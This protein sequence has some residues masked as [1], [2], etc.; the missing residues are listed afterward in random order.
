[1]SASLR[2]E[3]EAVLR[4]SAGTA[5]GGPP[6]TVEEVRHRILL[7][8]LGDELERDPWLRLTGVDALLAHDAGHG[9]GYG[10][11]VTAWLDELGDVATA[12]H[13]LRVHPN[14]LRHRLRRVRELF[15]LDL[16]DP[17][18]GWRC[19][20]SSGGPPAVGPALRS[21]GGWAGVRGRSCPVAPRMTPRDRA[22]GPGPGGPR[23][24]ARSGEGPAP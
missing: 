9:T 11:S 22:A 20:W 18:S 14:T 8:R 13:R 1:A 12:A 24:R 4:A 3:A 17:T 19:G 5:A 10:A 16:G 6:V 15:G 21:T 7:D 2:R 23:S